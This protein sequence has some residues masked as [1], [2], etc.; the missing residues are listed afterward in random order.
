[1]LA[2]EKKA[3]DAEE[4]PGAR[5]APECNS[6]AHQLRGETEGGLAAAVACVAAMYA[7]SEGPGLT[8]FSDGGERPVAE[9]LALLPRIPK[10][11]GA[12]E[13]GRRLQPILEM[14][15]E[16]LAEAVEGPA[17]DAATE[18][19]LLGEPL[20]EALPMAVDDALEVRSEA[21]VAELM[22]TVAGQRTEAAPPRNRRGVRPEPIGREGTLEVTDPLPPPPASAPRENWDADPPQSSARLLQGMRERD[23]AFGGVARIRPNREPVRCIP[24]AGYREDEIRREEEA[25]AGTGR[26]RKKKK[27]RGMNLDKSNFVSLLFDAEPVGC[28]R[29]AAAEAPVAPPLVAVSTPPQAGCVRDVAAEAPVAPPLVAISAPPPV[30]PALRATR[31]VSRTVRE[32]GAR[33]KPT[34]NPAPPRREEEPGEPKR[35]RRCGKWLTSDGCRKRGSQFGGLVPVALDRSLDPP[36]YA[37]F[38]CGNRGHT[39]KHCPESWR[40]TVCYNCGRRGMTLRT[41]DRCGPAHLAYLA[42]KKEERLAQ[43][44]AADLAP[45]AATPPP[46]PMEVVGERKG[47]KRKTRRSKRKG[48]VPVLQS[49]PTPSGT[50]VEAA[51]TSSA[52]TSGPSGPAQEVGGSSGVRKAV[53]DELLGGLPAPLRDE[54]HLAWREMGLCSSDPLAESQPGE[55]PD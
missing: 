20:P 6:E 14:E 4:A 18:A 5:E 26:R 45:S 11:R 53:I 37:C 24:P 47:P 39:M 50:A 52:A 33:P 51:S 43:S 19:R 15:E 9:R 54:V 41:C 32:E 28:V 34:P 7:R 13:E 49:T 48:K 23:P 36:S 40:G 3:M 16:L 25:R 55:E 1:M 10:R 35:R 38:N 17:V 44:G 12:S 2:M 30:R 42:D 27:N 46:E 31:G 21:A 8:A 22:S 29:D